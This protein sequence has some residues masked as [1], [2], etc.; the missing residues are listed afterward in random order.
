VCFEADH[1][2]RR[3]YDPTCYGICKNCHAKRT[4]RGET[5]H[6]S[7]GPAGNPFLRLGHMLLGVV[8]YLTFIVEHLRPAAEI[9]FKLAEMGVSIEE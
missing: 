2:Y 6:P 3:N 8:D 5:E 7:V 9:M 4:A 1:I